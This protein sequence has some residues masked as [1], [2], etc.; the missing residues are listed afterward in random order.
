MGV[1]PTISLRSANPPE[2][3]PFESQAFYPLPQTARRRA[4]KTFPARA[5][6]GARLHRRGESSPS[7]PLPFPL[8]SSAWSRVAWRVARPAAR[9]LRGCSRH[10]RRG[11]SQRLCTAYSRRACAA[12]RGGPVWH[13]SMPDVAPC[14][15]ARPWHAARPPARLLAA[16][17]GAAPA[18]RCW[19]RHSAP[20]AHTLAPLARRGPLRPGSRPWRAVAPRRGPG[21]RP[22]LPARP[23]R[24]ATPSTLPAQLARLRHERG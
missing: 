9:A 13:S 1:S 20:L 18:R 8:T 4:S 16:A 5:R 2:T 6:R 10:P 12:A 19:R 23:W 21:A 7:F 17:P 14:C 3:I 11:C 15:L 22:A 24:T